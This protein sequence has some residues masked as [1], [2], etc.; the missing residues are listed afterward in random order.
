MTVVFRAALDQSLISLQRQLR[1]VLPDGA[2]VTEPGSPLEHMA[3]DGP[4]PRLVHADIIEG[5]VMRARRVFGDPVVRFAAF[6]DGTQTSHVVAYADG[7]PLVLGTVAAVVRQ[8]RNRR[9]TTWQRPVVERRLYASL[10]VLAP[11]QR[12]ALE[13]LDVGIVDT[14][15]HSGD[16]SVHPF[17]LRDEAVHRVQEDRERAEQRLGE[18]WCSHEHEPLLIDGGISGSEKVA[19]SECVVGVVKSH[20]TLYAEGEALQ[21]IFRLRRGERSSVLRITSHKRVPIAS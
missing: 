7:A 15:P 11:D 6:L 18:A 3:P 14:T 2:L 12:R 13:A 4:P 1:A 19:I 5:G 20:R 17:T 16:P 8:R 21:T 10:R 9:L